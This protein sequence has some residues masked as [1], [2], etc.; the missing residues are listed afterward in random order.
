LHEKDRRGGKP[1]IRQQAGKAIKEREI[2]CPDPIH[3]SLESKC[4]GEAP[5]RPAPH[6]PGEGVHS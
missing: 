5:P 3:L 4:M 2:I 1:A 6:L